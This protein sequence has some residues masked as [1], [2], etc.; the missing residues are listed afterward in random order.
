MAEMRPLYVFPRVVHT[1]LRLD[2]P[3]WA[4]FERATQQRGWNADEGVQ[5]VL[6][7]LAAVR[8][9]RGLSEE[10]AANELSAARAMLAFLHDHRIAVEKTIHALEQYHETIVDS[11]DG[12]LGAL[13][14]LEQQRQALS[15]RLAVLADEAVRR[16]VQGEGHPR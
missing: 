7:Y 10:D 2:A 13:H 11:L 9:E 3:T 1:E 4:R 12:L 15:D 16:G 8:R 5:A 14:S 6:G